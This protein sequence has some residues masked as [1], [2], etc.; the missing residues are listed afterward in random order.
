MIPSLLYKQF[1]P[2]YAPLPLGGGGGEI[3]GPAFVLSKI[4]PNPKI[5]SIALT[6]LQLLK[7]LSL[8]Y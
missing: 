3:F 7:Y 2:G 8:P 1:I 4:G 5:M 6:V